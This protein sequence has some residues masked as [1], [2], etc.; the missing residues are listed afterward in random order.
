MSASPLLPVDPPPSLPARLPAAP[1]ELA[2]RLGY[3]GLLPFGFGA[4]L[5]MVVRADVQPYVLLSLAVYAGIIVSFLGGIHWALAMLVLAVPHRRLW[6]GVTLSLLAWVSVV[7]P[8]ASGLVI[9]AVLLIACYLID[10]RVYPAA[11]LS[12]WLTLRFRLTA[13]AALSC[14]LAAAQA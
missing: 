11:G 9:Q 8:P 10:R 5:S 3:A 4:L 12:K 14:F 1:D 6:T 13:V 7:M 2:L